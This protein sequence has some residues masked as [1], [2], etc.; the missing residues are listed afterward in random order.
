MFA[1]RTQILRKAV[2]SFANAVL[3][4]L[5]HRLHPVLPAAESGETLYEIVLT[6]RESDETHLRAH[7]MVMI[8]QESATLHGIH[9]EDLEG[10]H[11]T[12]RRAEVVTSG[13]QNSLVERIAMA[14]SIEPS[15]SSLSWSLVPTGME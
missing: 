11:R 6:C 7:L 2:K 14:L 9:S 3:R 1:I 12:R 13:R 5:A 15:V 4:P 10:T 8:T